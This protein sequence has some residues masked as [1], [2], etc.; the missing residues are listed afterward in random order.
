MEL[1][2]GHAIHLPA[3]GGEVV[4]DSA[5]RRL[6][7]LSDREELVA[8]WTRFGP[9]RDGASAHVH[10]EHNDLFYVLEGELTVFAGPDRVDHVLRPG[11]LALAP[12]LVVHGFRNASDAD[13]KYLNF[14]VPGGGF[15]AYI[16]GDAPGFD[17]FDPP[18][19]GGGPLEDAYVGTGEVL[20]DRPGL[21]VALLVDVDEIAIVDV[22]SA[23]GGS[24]P[25]PPLHV[26]E[27]HVESF[28]VVAGELAFTAGGEELSATAGSW[29]QV[30]PNVPHSFAPAGSEPA[31]YVNVHTPSR[32]F[33]DFTHALLAARN[34]DELV[35]ARA[36]F[37][38]RAV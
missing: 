31:R 32:G 6:E 33:G 3:A 18:E 26:H 15:A 28:Y 34:E 36:A 2:V 19:D 9:H 29:V 17:S 37:D 10:R 35:A 22:T 13:V 24:A 4:G 20:S 5:E 30:P 12:P 1:D 21:Q 11:T 25:T 8:T 14:H 16:R 38:Q 23:P 7:I 27:R